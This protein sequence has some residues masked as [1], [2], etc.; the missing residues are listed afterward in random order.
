MESEI[1]FPNIA[2]HGF[3]PVRRRDCDYTAR[4]FHGDQEKE[5]TAARCH[6]LLRALTSRVAILK[7]D[8]ARFS[9]VHPDCNVS[10]Q[11][12]GKGSQPRSRRKRYEDDDLDWGQSKSRKRVKRTYTSRSG[13]GGSS[14]GAPKTPRALPSSSGEKSL[15]PGE[16]SVPTPIL[17]RARG[18]LFMG[19]RLSTSADSRRDGNDVESNK[20]V[21]G[22]GPAND[23][24]LHF[25]TSGTLRE[26]RQRTPASRY[27]IYEGLYH[28][29]ETLLRSTGNEE[30]AKTRKG[31]R[32][33]LST[34]LR[35]VPRHIVQEDA[36]LSAHAEE[37]GTRSAIST[38]DMSTEIYD[39]LEDFGSSGRGWKQLKY[40]V[41]AHGVQV[42]GEAIRSGLLDIEFCRVLIALCINTSA[43]EEAEVLLSS[44]LSSSRFPR[45]RTLHE[46]APRS[47]SMLW[48]FVQD[49]GR[50][51]FQYQQLAKLV[52][53]GVLPLEWLATKAFRPVWT[54]VIQRLSPG[55]INSDALLFFDEM[56]PLLA[57]AGSS[58]SSFEKS[59]AE[60]VNQ[61]FSSL[62]TTLVSIVILSTCDPGAPGNEPEALGRDYVH[63]VALLRSALAQFKLSGPSG[64]EAVL[65]FAAN[66]LAGAQFG[67]ADFELSLP[68]SLLSRHSNDSDSSAEGSTDYYDLV[69]F[70]CSVARCCGRGASSTGFEHLEHLHFILQ[71]FTSDEA[72]ASL[73]KCLMVDSAFAFAQQLPERKHLE[74]ASSLDTKF[75]DRDINPHMSPVANISDAARSGFRWEEGI[76]EWIMETPIGNS[77]KKNTT[78]RDSLMSEDK[79]EPPPL[80][81]PY[82]GRRRES[83]TTARFARTCNPPT[84]D[85]F[86]P[87]TSNVMVLVGPV[88]IDRS[89]APL[90]YIAENDDELDVTCYES[91]DTSG[92]GTLVS[93]IKGSASQ[94]SPSPPTP[95]S[96]LEDGEYDGRRHTIEPASRFTRKV[97]RRNQDWPV[98]NESPNVSASSSPSSSAS[99]ETQDDGEGRQTIKRGPRLGRR[100]L[101]SGQAW[102]VFD[103][104]DD[105]LSFLSVSTTD[106]RVFEDITNTTSNR[107]RHACKTR[108]SKQPSPI[109]NLGA[110][111]DSEDELCI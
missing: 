56:L 21:R 44:L 43:R 111:T 17:A 91:D 67:S 83:M 37:T 63:L 72:W 5:W 48:K 110:I 18:D 104:S 55:S 22:Q 108:K 40:V 47:V 78:R 12:T 54:G 76:G 31:A 69:A 96:C 64:E 85:Q 3:T 57:G 89:L 71:R 87:S 88:A 81:S 105:E 94:Q 53:T 36:I 75:L 101:R 1:P 107:T 109:T 45:P 23:G 98:F 9:S 30:L 8:L 77:R 10:N 39:E 38:H 58:T 26:I 97:V 60:A 82:L 35:A 59:S 66:L 41:R 11:N 103:E 20:D 99:Y 46:P 49:T 50:F 52:S 84:S 102:Q 34:C 73:I 25:P 92:S 62:L 80:R 61:T 24:E 27:T 19:E 68:E 16:I 29:F 79:V 13:R 28:G 106:E 70:I 100:A 7:K 93:D 15:I 86:H 42:L 4:Q 51:S 14:Q 65:L 2:L 74:Y 90:L 33:L 32:S 6:R 95:S